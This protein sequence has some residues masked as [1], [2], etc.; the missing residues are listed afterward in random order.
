MAISEHIRELMSGSS[1]I[2]KMFEAGA[3]LKA[4]HG[5]DKV[6][7]FSLGNPNLA[8][9]ERFPQTIRAILDEQVPAKHSYMQN[10]GYLETRKAVAKT[11]SAEQAVSIGENNIIMTTG[12]GGA[13]NIALKAILNPG[14]TVLVPSP[15]FMEYRFYADNHGAE[16][17]PVPSAAGFEPDITALAAAVDKRTAAVIINSPN[18]PT[19]AVYSE[20]AIAELGT[21]LEKKSRETGRSIY[22]ISDEPYRHIVFDGLTVPPVMKHYRNTI[23]ATSY[24]KD[25]SIPGERIGWAAVHPEADGGD[26]LAAGMILANRILGYV[27]APALMQR[28]AARLQGEWV[29]AEIYRKKRDLLCDGLEKAGYELTRPAGTFYL[30]L[31]APGGDDEAFVEKLQKQLILAVPGRGFGAPGYIRLSFCVADEVING[32]MPG[33]EAALDA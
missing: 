33:F 23:V 17:V 20:N 29:D 5:A 18:N 11:A 19:G 6:Y 16:L 8:P 25:L 14:D 4:E 24:S 30:F 2:R 31:P 22:L 32:A 15:F 7:D 9:P 13:M 12:A 26:E 1:W 27:N 10:A 21:M 3:R 28:A